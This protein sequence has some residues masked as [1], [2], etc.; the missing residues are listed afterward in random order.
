M[1]IRLSLLPQGASPLE[2]KSGA[3]ALVGCEGGRM[4]R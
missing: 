2:S 1:Q 3:D 4:V